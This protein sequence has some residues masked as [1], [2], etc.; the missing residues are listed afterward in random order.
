MALDVASVKEDLANLK[1]KKASI[2]RKIQGL[3]LYL[4]VQKTATS[5]TVNTGRVSARGGV[6]ISPSVKAV[7]DS[8]GNQSV[9]YKDLVDMVAQ[10]HTDLD[11][12]VVDRKLS[13]LKRTMLDSAGYGKYQL[14]AQTPT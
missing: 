7:F 1:E 11:R 8:N 13:H 14:K 3:E 6:D 9:K 2:E 5:K 12:I 10:K 4:G